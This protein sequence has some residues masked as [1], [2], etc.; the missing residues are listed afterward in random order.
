MAAQTWLAEHGLAS[1]IRIG[2]ERPADGKFGAHA[3]LVH[4]DAVVTG[5]DVTR[6]DVL[7]ESAAGARDKS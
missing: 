3:W 6:Y 7:L 5:G 2:V 4:N 1:E